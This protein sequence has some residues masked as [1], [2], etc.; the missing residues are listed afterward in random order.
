MRP[1]RKRLR[2]FWGTS[3]YRAEGEAGESPETSWGGDNGTYVVTAFEADLSTQTIELATF[4][5][6]A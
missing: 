4:V 2:P 1:S 3:R 6:I 5:L